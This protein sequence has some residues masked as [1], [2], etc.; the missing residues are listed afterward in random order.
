MD[1][2]DYFALRRYRFTSIPGTQTTH[3]MGVVKRKEGR[4]EETEA[5]K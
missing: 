2:S 5:Y 1:H 4:V 3:T